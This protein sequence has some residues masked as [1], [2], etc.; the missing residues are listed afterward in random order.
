MRKKTVRDIDV[1]GKRVLT[2]VDFNVPLVQRAADGRR[3][4]ADDT[5]ISAALPTIQYLIEND[6]K[7]ILM[8]HMGRPKGKRDAKLSLEPT[9]RHLSGL[10]GKKVRMAPDCVGST[11]E[12]MVDALKDGDVLLLENV[13]FHIREKENNPEFA[14]QLARLGDIYVNDAFGSAHRA[15]ASTTGVAQLLPLAVAGFL[16]E[17]EI[18]YLGRVLEKPSRPFVAIL[19]GAKI[20]D[21]LKV[22][23]SLLGKV[24]RLLI[25]GG[26][27]NTFLQ[28]KGCQ[29]GDSLVEESSLELA[30]DLLKRGA[31]KMLLPVDLVAADKF[32]AAAGWQ[33]V[34]AEKVPEGWRALDISHKTIELFSNVIAEA[35][36]ILWNGPMGVFEF[37]RFAKGTNAIAQAVADSDATSIVGGGDSVA[38][39]H[40]AGVAERISHISTGGGAS[41]QF[42]E[43]EPLPG[44]AALNDR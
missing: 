32:D 11:A 14:A 38:A 3:E 31:D 23:E 17:K 24:D 33:H 16:M 35:S 43:G 12:K 7:L 29:M 41:L 4:V 9:A 39:I 37:P 21:K 34:A 10:L 25:G 44:I 28:A 40:Q 2:R 22:I 5:R 1:K 30:S 27:A 36:M 6:A 15:H 8:S 42:L 18:D 26:M 20:S 19:G 13:R